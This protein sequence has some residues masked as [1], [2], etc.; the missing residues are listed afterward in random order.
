MR[1]LALP[2]D[3][4]EGCVA[5]IATGV[6]LAACALVFVPTAGLRVL[7]MFFIWGPAVAIGIGAS[8]HARQM[9][10]RRERAATGLC[11]SCGYDLRASLGRCPEC[12][13]RQDE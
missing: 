9:R 6:P 13:M 3:V 11:P 7:L 2:A 4:M 8:L 12:G 10:L 1:R 5:T